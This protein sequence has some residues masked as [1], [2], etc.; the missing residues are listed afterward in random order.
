MAEHLSKKEFLISF[1]FKD[2]LRQFLDRKHRVLL[3]ESSL[4][5]KRHFV[6]ELIEYSVHKNIQEFPS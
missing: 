4:D 6:L 2:F 1:V 3:L 5:R